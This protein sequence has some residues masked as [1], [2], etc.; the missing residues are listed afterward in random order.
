MTVEFEFDAGDSWFNTGSG[1]FVDDVEVVEGYPV[2]CVGDGLKAACP[3]QNQSAHEE[4]AGCAHSQGVGARLR[5]E[6]SASLSG[7]TLTL[8]GSAM[9]NQPVL[10]FQAAGSQPAAPFGDGLL[11]AAQPF[12]RLGTEINSGG[13]SSYPGPGDASISVRGGIGAPGVRH[14]QAW[15][16]DPS[17]WCGPETF[18]LSNAVTVVW[19]L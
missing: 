11:C 16:R 1:P 7:D 17:P 6:G 3:C 13:A 15:Y 14:Y 8:R 10:Y 18:N 19:T 9:P 5:A 12:V 2:S 4:L